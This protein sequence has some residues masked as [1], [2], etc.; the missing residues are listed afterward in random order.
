MADEKEPIGEKKLK[1]EESDEQ[2]EEAFEKAMDVVMKKTGFTMKEY[3][4]VRDMVLEAGHTSAS[5]R[6]SLKVGDDLAE[7]ALGRKLEETEFGLLME[8]YVSCVTITLIVML[9]KGMVCEEA[10]CT[11]RD[12]VVEELKKGLGSLR[13]GGNGSGNAN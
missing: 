5:V 2:G 4:R 10:T 1:V 8:S 7:A 9:H 6:A 11:L 13:G 12:K 3:D